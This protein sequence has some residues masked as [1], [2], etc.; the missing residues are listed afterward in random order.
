M[1][2]FAAALGQV[3]PMDRAARLTHACVHFGIAVAGGL[4]LWWSNRWL[5]VV[6]TC[7]VLSLVYDVC[8]R[9]RVE[10]RVTRRQRAYDATPDGRLTRDHG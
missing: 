6:P 2:R 10:Q 9:E 1:R 3:R 5:L 4:L 7:L 8:L